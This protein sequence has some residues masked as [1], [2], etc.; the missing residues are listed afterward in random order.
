MGSSLSYPFHLSD[1]LP[2]LLSADDIEVQTEAAGTSVSHQGD[3]QL[4]FLKHHFLVLMA[5]VVFFFFF[6]FLQCCG[7]FV[8]TAGTLHCDEC[9][10]ESLSLEAGP[11]WERV[12]HL[13]CHLTDRA[14]ATPGAG[15]HS[16]RYLN[17]SA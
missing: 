11:P 17:G 15:P 9:R 2:F 8:F 10:S 3:G 12:S 4:P 14:P 16:G 6:V 1:I 13:A 7:L 5:G